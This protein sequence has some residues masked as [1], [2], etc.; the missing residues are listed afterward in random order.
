MNGFLHEL[1]TLDKSY[2]NEG[3]SKN[4]HYMK[5]FLDFLSTSGLMVCHVK[6]NI[7]VI[8]KGTL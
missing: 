3:E 1:V 8:I 5:F 2:S 6:R 7:T 4:S